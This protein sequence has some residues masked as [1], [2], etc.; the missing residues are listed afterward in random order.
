MLVGLRK[1]VNAAHVLAFAALFVAL[2]GFAYALGT[3]SVKSKHIAPGQVKLSDL[4][5]KVRTEAFQVTDDTGEPG[6]TF[7]FDDADALL[8]SLPLKK[9]SYV[10]SSTFEME[11]DSGGLVLRCQLRAGNSRDEVEHFGFQ[12]L[13]S[14]ALGVAHKFG[15]NGTAEL[16]CLDGS[17]ADNSDINDIEI[18]ATKV[19][20]VKGS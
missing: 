18:I 10:I 17:A 5:K 6:D 14:G 16:R 1:R 3:N 11:A 7:N 2:G 19:A 13:E 8:T 4:N 12:G 15:S 9:G 20:K